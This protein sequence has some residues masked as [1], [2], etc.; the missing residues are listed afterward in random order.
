MAAYTTIDDAASFYNTTLYTGTG[1]ELAVTGVGFSADFTWIKDRD[2]LGYHNLFDTVRGATKRIFSNVANAENTEAQSLK[3]WQSDG[4]TVGTHADCNTNTDDL[5]SW[6]WLA[7]TT[8]GIA[9]SPSITPT[10]YSFNQTSGFSIIQYAGTAAAA[11]LPHGLGVAPGLI[12]IKKTTESQSWGVYHK[13]L[14]ETKYLVLDTTAGEATATAYWNDTA[15]TSTLFSVGDNHAVNQASKD[16]IAYCFA[17]IKGYSKMGGYPGNGDAD[18]TF[19]YTGFRPAF[20]LIKHYTPYAENWNIYD[21]KRLGYNPDNDALNPNVAT[22]GYTTDDMNIV[23]NG[24][25]L[26]TTNSRVND[27]SYIYAAFASN[28]FVNSSGVPGNAC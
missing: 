3:S 21:D 22:T 10:A 28:P 20:V 15:P 6:N 14:G 13:A 7:G 24:F 9:G 23:S 8:S 2:G 19:V 11:T 17:D 27:G 16:F 18:G 4:F 5:V 12:M 25:K 1:S 26:T